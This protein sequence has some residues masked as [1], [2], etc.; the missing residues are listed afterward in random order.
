LKSRQ[1]PLH[2]PFPKGEREEFFIETIQK[3]SPPFEKSRT[4]GIYE[5][6]FQKTKVIRFLQKGI[7][8]VSQKVSRSVTPAKA[9]V[10]NILK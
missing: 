4:G 10:Q 8:M 6:P 3:S 7:L 2:P 5:P 9:G 1:I